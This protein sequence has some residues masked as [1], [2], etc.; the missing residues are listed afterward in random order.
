M[1]GIEEDVVNYY[2]RFWSKFEQW[3]D[4]KETL[5]IHLG[6]F[7][8]STT[9]HRQSV[10]R[11]NEYTWDL[12]KLDGTKP[13]L[14]LDVGCGIGGTSIY[15]AKKYPPVTFTGINITPLQIELARRFSAER[16]VISNTKFLEKNFC[17]TGFPTN[18]FDGVFALESANYASDRT[19]FVNEMYR[20]IK[21]GGRFVVLD[22]LL[23]E[24]PVNPVL[25]R[26]FNIW[27]HG[28]ALTSLEPLDDF[29]ISMDKAGF[30]DIEVVDISKHVAPSAIRSSIIGIPFFFSALIKIIVTL[31]HYKKVENYDY[32]IGV[33]FLGSLLALGGFSS[34]Y[35]VVGTK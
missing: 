20:V 24:K 23:N 13:L 2:E 9:T 29:V 6:Y 3:W 32:F 12:L 30:R 26:L 31:N 21:P 8:D 17:D 11:M 14:V 15:L 34:Y 5:G 27:L 7:D 22:G 25:Q 16:K 18:S 4:A 19:A 28:R 1:A 33:S 10:L 35:A